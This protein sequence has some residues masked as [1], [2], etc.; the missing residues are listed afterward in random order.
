MQLSA[1]GIVSTNIPESV[2]FY[3][4]L[5]LQF[6]ACD[7]TTQ[8]TEATT[9][10][11][12]RIMLDAEELIKK[13]KPHW[14]KPTIASMALAFDCETPKGVDETFKKITS[15]GFKS[16]KEPWDAFWGQRYATVQDPDGNSIDLF[17]A[18][19]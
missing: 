17:A 2:R 4:L 18:L 3:S 7:K 10:S 1:I 6:E 13:L 12:L 16:E 19:K 11:G 9:K 8:H 14:V 5:G 15:A